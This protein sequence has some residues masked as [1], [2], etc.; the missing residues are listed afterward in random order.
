MKNIRARSRNVAVTGEDANN[1]RELRARG[2]Y[3]AFTNLRELLKFLGTLLNSIAA[4]PSY[5]KQ[6]DER[7]P[8]E[9]KRERERE[10]ENASGASMP[11]I[12]RFRLDFYRKRSKS[13]EALSFFLFFSFSFLHFLSLSLS[14]TLTPFIA[15][16]FSFSPR[17]LER[18]GT[19][20]FTR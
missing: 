16:R 19:F 2:V 17:S 10:K 7:Y 14:L 9:R 6:K 11:I 5:G 1:Y 15:A 3:Q 8:R 13:V 12:I 18:G 4:I 20:N